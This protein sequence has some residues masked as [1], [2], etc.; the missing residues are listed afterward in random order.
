MI[1]ADRG[2]FAAN[3][4]VLC[5]VYDKPMS[6]QLAEVY[7]AVMV[8]YDIDVIEWASVEHVKASKFMP[9]PSELLELVQRRRRALAERAETERRE[10]LALPQTPEDIENGKRSATYWIGKMRD[11]VQGVVDKRRFT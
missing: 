7:F 11:L 3:L 9:R 6:D 5:E 8:P 1:P 10:R 4:A 2:R